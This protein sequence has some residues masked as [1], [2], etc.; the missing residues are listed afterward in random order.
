MV[1]TKEHTWANFKL[2]FE[3]ARELLK[4]VRGPNMTNTAFQQANMV[5]E[6]IRHDM[7]RQEQNL[8][9]SIASLATNKNPNEGDEMEPI[10]S[11]VNNVN[12]TSSSTRSILAILKDI[13]DKLK[14]FKENTPSDPAKRKRR[15]TEYCWTHGR[16]AHKSSECRNKKEGHKD[17]ATLRNKKGG[18]KKNCGERE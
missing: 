17:D 2:H 4:R 13:E 5:A 6:S 16:C 3:A 10:D 9:N 11:N 1:P 8:L 12:A 14:A 18:S 7:Y 15:L